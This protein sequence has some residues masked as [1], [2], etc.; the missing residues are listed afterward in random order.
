MPEYEFDSDHRIL[1]TKLKTPCTRRSRWRK[2]GKPHSKPDV[3]S[4]KETEIRKKLQTI[5]ADQ[6]E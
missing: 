2:E 3:K 4:I 6:L 1:I 5:C